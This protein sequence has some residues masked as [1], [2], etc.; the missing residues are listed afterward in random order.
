[1]R[2]AADADRVALERDL[3]RSMLGLGQQ[4]D[5]TPFLAA[6]IDMVLGV[7]GAR[8]A[9][10]EIGAPDGPQYWLAS[11][12][13]DAELE[14]VRGE[15]SRGI[16]AKALATGQSVSTASALDDPRFASQGS[17]QAR[18]IRAVL[19]VPVGAPPAFGV[20]YLQGR[21][22]AGPF[23]ADDQ[24]LAEIF[25]Q[26]LA[27][28]ADSLITREED[29]QRYD[30]TRELRARLDVVDIAGTSRP[31]A[32]LFESL[33]V[34]APVDISVLITGESGTGKTAVA[35]A[36]HRSS[37]R[38][39]KPF[40]EVN[41][42][43]IPETLFESE[44]FGAEKGAHSTAHQR[45]E[46]KVDA[47]AGG[48]LFLDEVGE[49]P[50]TAQS[51]LLSFLQ[52]KTYSRLGSPQPLEADVRI[53]AAT[54]ADL[55]ELVAGKRFREDLYY[56]LSVLEVA[57]PSLRERSEDI[58]TIADA[59]AIAVGRKNGALLPLSPGARRA[60]SDGEW[61]GNVRQ[62]ENVIHRGWATAKAHGARAIELRHVFPKSGAESEA[63]E[64]SYHDAMRRFQTRLVQ[65][66][67]EGEGWNVSAAAR[68]LEVSR[69]YLNELIRTLALERPAKS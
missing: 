57:V 14:A 67:L 37:P 8:K 35:R 10:L 46:G 20:V 39:E 54:N 34:A 51:K 29:A 60:L 23:T 56:R 68:R 11:G 50:L 48:T 36:L 66:A 31:L 49:I 3:Y 42:A 24:E 27:P 5:V 28:L 52:G 32:A 12:F 58:P 33:L 13:V 64:L 41:C 9:Y 43:A 18:Q 62:L 40:I 19:C 69:S 47:A 45:I 6:A 65:E 55:P 21:G 63:G 2:V 25:A 53:V 22:E 30:H 7:T 1:M 4:H 26:Q 38:R 17:V 61:P 16:V 59:V 15:I 44:L